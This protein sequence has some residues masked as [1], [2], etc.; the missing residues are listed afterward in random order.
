MIYSQTI[1]F[2]LKE[3]NNFQVV[4]I[5]ENNKY[6]FNGIGYI[7]GKETEFENEMKITYNDA[8]DIIKSIC[9]KIG[10]IKNIKRIINVKGYGLLSKEKQ[11]HYF[12]DNVEVI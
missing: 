10:G 12:G 1:E 8:L 11:S 4:I 2:N 6:Y 3:G 9:D 5:S 7:D